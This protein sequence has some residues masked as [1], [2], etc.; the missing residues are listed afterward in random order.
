MT[1][2]V[3]SAAGAGHRLIGQPLS[4]LQRRLHCRV[5]LSAAHRLSPVRDESPA[6]T[7]T[8]TSAGCRNGTADSDDVIV[9]GSG[10]T[11]DTK[12]AATKFQ[13][14]LEPGIH[15]GMQMATVAERRRNDVSTA[16]GFGSSR[17]VDLA[18][19][20]FEQSTAVPV[21]SSA[22]QTQQQAASEVQQSR[23]PVK[24]GRG[25]PRKYTPK[26][27]DNRQQTKLTSSAENSV[28]TAKIAAVPRNRDFANEATQQ[29]LICDKENISPLT[30]ATIAVKRL[31]RNIWSANVVCDAAETLKSG[32]SIPAEKSTGLHQR[33]KLA[34]L[35]VN[36]LLATDDNNNFQKKPTEKTAPDFRFEDFDKDKLLT[37]WNALKGKL[38][39]DDWDA[40]NRRDPVHDASKGQT[41]EQRTASTEVNGVKLQDQGDNCA[42]E[43][44]QQPDVQTPMLGV[45]Q[46]SDI[47]SIKTVHWKCPEVND[48]GRSDNKISNTDELLDEDLRKIT[49][50]FTDDFDDNLPLSESLGK[51]LFTST[52]I[53]L[54]SACSD[55]VP[56]KRARVRFR[57]V[58]RVGNDDEEDVGDRVEL[59]KLA[60]LPSLQDGAVSS[61]THISGVRPADIVRAF[62]TI[63]DV[64]AATSTLAL[65]PHGVPPTLPFATVHTALSDANDHQPLVEKQNNAGNA[66]PPSVTSTCSP[67]T[68]MTTSSED[69]SQLPSEIVPAQ[70]LHFY[71][72]HYDGPPYNLSPSTGRFVTKA[73]RKR[74]V[75]D[76]VD[77]PE[78]KRFQP[79][80]PA[81][82]APAVSADHVVVAPTSGIRLPA[83]T[84]T[85]TETQPPPVAAGQR[86]RAVDG[87]TR[88]AVRRAPNGVAV[89]DLLRLQRKLSA[90][91]DAATL[92][93]VVQI[94]GETGRYY[95]NDVTFDFD[96]CK[97]D[98][99]T[100]SRL[101]QC[102]SETSAASQ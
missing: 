71:G 5:A 102:L 27:T 6:G 77:A 46:A 43:H 81:G 101:N 68:T 82:Y 10:W 36:V 90:A 20:N 86:H 88:D 16:D 74:P 18:P 3:N 95:V 39:K 44:Q 19:S 8:A 35:P 24:R 32:K 38:Q 85:G 45:E 2:N 70:L 15:P 49:F 99:A 40:I 47:A 83:S 92:R 54:T 51:P 65:P 69:A 97:I 41:A 72:T 63:D 67:A 22:P 37:V 28:T 58:T 73:A 62:R 100:V 34:E 33:Q 91:R 50:P 48:V 9:V 80:V 87:S 53:K 26:A 75:V 4:Y 94:I 93:R 7:T 60:A 61:A 52:P 14:K 31:K 89:D 55:A 42:K 1:S 30:S 56:V 84:G 17:I 23:K 78:R 57:P 29:R 12:R 98:S 59:S 11:S 13:P 21:I 76:D 66:E 79:E 25:R 96:L 64:T